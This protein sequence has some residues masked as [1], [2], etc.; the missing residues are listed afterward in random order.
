M[1]A[2]GVIVAGLRGCER[3][4][5]DTCYI[6]GVDGRTGQTLWRTST[7]A[8]PGERGGDSW[9]DLPLLFRAGADAWIPGS[10][11]PV[12][13][14]VFYGTSQAKPW[15]RDARGTEGDALYSNSTLALDP[16]TGEMQWYFQHIP[17]DSHDMD[18]TFERILIDVDGQPSIYSMGKLGILWQLDRVTGDYINA[19]DLGYQ[20]LMDLNRET[21]ELTYRDG[22]VVDV[23]EEL[24]FCPSTGGFKGL[25]AMA[26]H[27]DTEALY[28][29]LNLQCE[30][31]AF[32]PVE[33]R[34]GGGGTG[35]VRGRQNHFH[36]DAPDQLGEVRAMNVRTGETLWHNRR[37]APYNTAALTTA[38]GLVFIGDWERYIFAYDAETGDQL[39]QTRLSTM[40]NG[41]PISYAV[42]GKQYIAFGAG[43]PLGGSSWTSIIPADLVPR[44]AQPESGERRLRVRLALT[45]T[46][47]T[48]FVEPAGTRSWVQRLVIRGRR[49]ELGLGAAALVPL[50]KAREQALANRK[51]ARSG[52]DHLS[53]KRRIRGVPTLA[54]A[55]QRVLEQKRGGWRGQWH[56]QNWWR[57]LE[58][59]AFPRIG[60]RPV[61]EFNTADVLEILTPIWHV[62]AETA[63]AVR[64]RR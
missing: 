1:V 10:Y 34:E 48:F 41:Y 17:G 51:L 36:P 28:V 32:G 2:D 39:W 24:F 47:C 16:A 61:S 62:K 19:T 7:I 56:A 22:A 26:Y 8:R 42:D 44:D 52:G 6:V 3:F 14:L 4:R 13:R 38:G 35:G 37:R 58:R 53:E 64:Q 43:S 15:T 5:E 46:A 31:A 18:E 59:Y 49:R 50:A 60:R 11:D 9:G 45:A 33:R 55:A 63:R 12:N 29:P 54:E 25:R 40:S 57:S 27:P 23:G 21:G 20:N 30:T